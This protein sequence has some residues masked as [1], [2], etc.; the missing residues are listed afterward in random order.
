M[1]FKGEVPL[2]EGVRLRELSAN[3]G[4][5]VQSGHPVTDTRANEFQTISSRHLYLWCTC[6]SFFSS[7][8]TAYSRNC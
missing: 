6:Y 3:G 5:T 2:T 8:S 4:S 7:I 1:G